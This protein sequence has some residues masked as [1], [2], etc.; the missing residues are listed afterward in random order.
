LATGQIYTARQALENGL[1]D[2]TGYDDDATEDLKTQLGLKSV[3]IV[4]YQF[5]SSLFDVLSA[6]SDA[7]SRTAVDPLKRL[8]EA[9]TPRA[10]Y[11]FGWRPGMATE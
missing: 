9:N 4:E 3:R 10:M 8:F 2:V 11:L 5:P 7:S 1:V 6:S